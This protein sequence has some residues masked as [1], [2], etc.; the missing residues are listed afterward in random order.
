MPSLAQ[1]RAQ[2]P[3]L[4]DGFVYLENAGG[5][6]VPAC[7]A[8]AI[9]TYMTT[10][11]VQLHATYEIS[12]RSTAVVLGAHDFMNRYVNGE[13]LGIAILGP[14]STQ[15]CY[16]LAE[17]YS[18]KLIPGDEVIICETAHEANAGPW[19]RL[20]RFGIVVR[21]WKINPDT[22]ECDLDDL[23]S[24]LNERTKLVAFPQVSNLL[25]DIVD[26]PAIT[27]MVHAAGARVVVDGVAYA[28]HR[29]IDVMAWDVDFYVYSTYKVFGPHMAVLFGKTEALSELEGPNHFFLP[30]NAYKFELGG[31]NHE[32]C[33]G[34]LA[35]GDYL[36]FLAETSGP[37]TRQTITCAW[38]V[39]ESLELTLQAKMMDYL[40]S[41]TDLK[42]IGPTRRDASRV[43]IFS[44][45]HP[46]LT[47]QEITA[48]TD[49]AGIG[50]RCGNM[51]AYRM[52]LA[53]GID[54]AVG[55]TR[56]SLA[57]YN[58]EE[59]LDRLIAVLETTR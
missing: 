48:R 30:S 36:N 11:Y 20:E 7:V 17:C 12:K 6:Q 22:Y 46:T 15:L 2:F 27:K 53:L 40:N 43:G 3:T 42:I 39:M 5:S 54:P 21:T 50:I 45:Q 34:L 4:A 33:A 32:G 44:F 18:R 16:M 19:A 41:R 56:I 10:N 9:R 8:D 47:P 58:S 57:H 59:E 1:V 28:P 13:G 51:Y 35:L 29:A 26:V 25:G 55:V 31:A 52:C 14:S 38:D 49:A 24:M 37:V 23:Q